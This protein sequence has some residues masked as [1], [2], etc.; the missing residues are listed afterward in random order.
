MGRYTSMNTFN[1]AEA[2]A[3]LKVH[4]QTLRRMTLEGVIDGSKVGKAWVFIEEDLVKY[5]RSLYRNGLGRTSNDGE[6]P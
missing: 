6:Q 4:P 5:I 2:A 1:L 3:F